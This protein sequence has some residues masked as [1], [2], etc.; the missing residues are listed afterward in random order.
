MQLNPR[1]LFD[2]SLVGLLNWH[3]VRLPTN[4]SRCPV[5]NDSLGRCLTHERTASLRMLKP[6]TPWQIHR[7][8]SGESS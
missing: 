2:P 3:T 6:Q 1:L 5:A 8:S 7:A 4:K